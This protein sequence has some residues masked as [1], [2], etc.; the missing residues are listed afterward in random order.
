MQLLSLYSNESKQDNEPIILKAQINNYGA[1]LCLQFKLCKGKHLYQLHDLNYLIEMVHNPKPVK[2]GKFFN[3]IIDPK[4]MDASSKRWL[5]F[6]KK[7][8]DARNLI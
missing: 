8:V 5:D 1:T 3:E 4:K 2:L 7:I 6:I